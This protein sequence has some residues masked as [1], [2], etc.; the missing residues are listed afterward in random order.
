V[1][2]QTS[3]HIIPDLVIGIVSFPLS[4]LFFTATATAA[5]A[6]TALSMLRNPCL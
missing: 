5:A 1:S 6:A 2:N 4:V 3:G